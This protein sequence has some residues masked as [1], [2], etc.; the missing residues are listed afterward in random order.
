MKISKTQ[1]IKLKSKGIEIIKNL[2][3]KLIIKIQ[4]AVAKRRVNKKQDWYIEISNLVGHN[5]NEDYIINYNG[6]NKKIAKY[7]RR[8]NKWNNRIGE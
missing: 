1:K 7:C 5:V 4:V 6:S 8:W 2:I 3:P